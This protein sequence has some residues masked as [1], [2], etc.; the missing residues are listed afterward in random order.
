MKKIFA[1]ITI[2]IILSTPAL[3][4][5]NY[6]KSQY[7]KG[8]FLGMQNGILYPKLWKLVQDKFGFLKESISN[9]KTK[10]DFY[11]FTFFPINI[12]LGDDAFHGAD[13]L[14]FIEWWYFDACLDDGYSIQVSINVYDALDLGL[15][16]ININIY[17]NGEIKRTGKEIYNLNEFNISRE[18]PLIILYDKKIIEGYIDKKTG[19]LIYALSLDINEI[20]LDLRFTS[21]TDGWKGTTPFGEWC[22]VMPKAEVDGIIKIGDNDY[23]HKVKGFG[24]HDHNWNMTI[25]A[26]INFGWIWGKVNSNNYTIIWC[27]ILTTWYLNDPVLVLNKENGTYVSINPE[28]IQIIVKDVRFKNGMLIPYSFSI[29]ACDKNISFSVEVKVIETH[30]ASIMGMVNYWRY[31]VRYTGS[32]TVFSKTENIDEKNIAEFIRFRPY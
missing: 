12:T 26:G 5:S 4:L 2:L 15:A 3:G 1:I 21:L 29:N 32:I 19:N 28:D 23:F 25:F 6:K 30:Y 7:S 14:H 24:Y 8:S 20:Y 31:H 10:G 13:T 17:K 22:V 9:K 16:V 18:L 27:D 11:D